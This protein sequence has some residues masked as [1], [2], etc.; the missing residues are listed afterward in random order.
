[1]EKREEEKREFDE[2]ILPA[3]LTAGKSTHFLHTKSKYGEFRY[4]I[5][6]ITL[7]ANLDVEV[8]EK[9]FFE[10]L[11]L[12]FIEISGGGLQVLDYSNCDVDDFGNRH[13]HIAPEQ[14]AYLEVPK[15]Q[16]G[17]IRIDFNP[18]HGMSSEGG[19]WL[20]ELL[21]KLPQKHFSR[22]DVAIDI[23]NAPEIRNYGVWKFGCS[24]K[25]FL[26]RNRE[27]ETTYWGKSSSRQ[28]IRLYN[29]KVEQEKRHGRIVNLDAWWRLE[30]QLRDNK[31]EEYPKLV[32]EMLE[33]FYKPAYKDANLTD[34][35]Q[36]KV[37]RMMNDLKYYGNQ[38]R[39]TQARLRKLMEKAKPENGL[40]YEIAKGFKDALPMLEKELYTYKGQFHIN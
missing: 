26:N 9:C 29:K 14:V 20:H 23:F 38:S 8:W 15:F 7:I 31:V 24:E 39:N 6:R 33:H 2:K 27:M 17:K 28:Q 3:Y 10:W 25:I 21:N 37:F 34:S 36:N 12:P 22:A 19:L 30:M 1:M 13:E 5:D 16:P 40:S 18:N 35:Q 11:G 32:V 4:S